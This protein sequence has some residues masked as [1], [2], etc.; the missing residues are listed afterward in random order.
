MIVLLPDILPFSSVNQSE[1]GLRTCTWI[2]L[3]ATRPP[4]VPSAAVGI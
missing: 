2:V 3:H 1:Q 4:L